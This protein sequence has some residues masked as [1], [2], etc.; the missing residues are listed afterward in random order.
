MEEVL[1]IFPSCL[2]HLELH[3]IRRTQKNCADKNVVL[4]TEV[5]STCYIVMYI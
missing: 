2:D 4:N 1:V 5:L 3:S